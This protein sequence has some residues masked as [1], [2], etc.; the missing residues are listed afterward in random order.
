MKKI[1]QPDENNK[2]KNLDIEQLETVGKARKVDLFSK[3]CKVQ[4]GHPG[5]ILSIFDIVNCIYNAGYLKLNMTSAHN[6]SFIMSKGHAAAAQYPFLVEKGF[7]GQ[8]DWNAWGVSPE[9]SLRVFGNIDIPGIDVTSGSLG[10]GV[11]IAAG[12][13]VANR[14]D[15]IDNVVYVI[16]SEGE[17]YEGSTW[18]SL[19]FCAHHGLSNVKI[20]VDVNKNMILGRPEDCLTLEDIE[21]KFQAFNFDTQRINGHDYNEIING[22]DFLNADTKA[23]RVLVADTIKGKGVSFLEDKPESHYWG[24]M[25]SEK[26]NLMMKELMS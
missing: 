17:L 2:M 1:K 21:R 12:M 24:N 4:E 15:K 25:S 8:D 19:L 13:A 9:S 14:N 3:L 26:M 23:P 16:I 7:I 22:L 5:S 18:E 6:D 10:H 20:V 11:G